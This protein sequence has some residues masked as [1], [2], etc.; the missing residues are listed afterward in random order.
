MS[1]SEAAVAMRFY[2]TP[3][4]KWASDDVLGCVGGKTHT[5]RSGYEDS[6]FYSP[7]GSE[8]DRVSE[9]STTDQQVTNE[10]LE[11][12]SLEGYDCDD[13]SGW[14]IEQLYEE[15]KNISREEESIEAQ[16]TS[17]R[18]KLDDLPP[19][20]VTA[21]KKAEETEDP[22]ENRSKQAVRLIKE[23]YTATRKELTES[24]CKKEAERIKETIKTERLFLTKSMKKLGFQWGQLKSRRERDIGCYG[25][26]N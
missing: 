9:S 16:L 11:V 15:T 3:T 26:A 19:K 5:E 13:F 7:K 14:T 22:V 20:K 17:M 2:R 12:A 23:K 1:V 10:D 21:E 24:L 8:C 4:S 18:A 6:E 25:C